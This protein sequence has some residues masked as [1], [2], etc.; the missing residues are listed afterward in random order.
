MSAPGG[1]AGAL[2][3]AIGFGRLLAEAVPGRVSETRPAD[4]TDFS[5]ERSIGADFRL[6]VCCR[7]GRYVRGDN[8]HFTAQATSFSQRQVRVLM[9]VRP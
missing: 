9:S 4:A 1:A 5:R 3:A 2:R 7:P 6:P 8:A